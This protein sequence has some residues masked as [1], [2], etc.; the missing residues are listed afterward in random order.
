MQKKKII[1]DL[2]KCSVTVTHTGV[3]PLKAEHHSILAQSYQKLPYVSQLFTGPQLGLWA[4]VNPVNPDVCDNINMIYHYPEDK[5]NVTHRFVKLLNRRNVF[6]KPKF[7]NISQFPLCNSWFVLV[8]QNKTELPKTRLVSLYPAAPLI[9][10]RK[11]D[12]IFVEKLNAKQFRRSQKEEHYSLIQEPGSTY[13]GHVSTSSSSS[14][15]I[16]QSIISR[17]S[18]LSMLLEKLEKNG[19]IHRLENHV[20][21]PL[22]WSICLL[23]FN[24][25]PF[26]HIFQ[27]I[28]GKTAGPTTFS[29]SIGQQLTN[30]EKLPVVDYEPIDCSVPDIDRNL[31][32]KDQQYLLDI[33]NAIT[34]GHCPEDLA[35]RDPGPL[36]HSRWLTAAN[37]VLRLYISSSY[38][39][40][41][42]K[43]IVGFNLKLYVPVWF[44]IKKNKYFTDGPKHVFQAIQTSR[45][46][47]DELLQVVDPVI[48]RNAFFG[49]PE[50]V[51]IAMLDKR[52]HI[53]KLGYRR[54]LKARQTVTKKKTVRNFVLPKINF[55][56]SDYIEIINWNSCVIYPPPLLR[57][58]S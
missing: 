43:E 25:L 10:G 29:G 32:S 22:Q 52:E 35:N 45:Y 51:L 53:R 50:N 34:L 17:L 5:P 2:Q 40:E 36:S 11:D 31:L 7:A 16:T 20:G 57:D 47:S 38:P 41:N 28:D 42:L 19:V 12:T 8:E 33:S 3:K 27:Y 18:E 56:A 4:L 46:F 44:A 23:H 39:S 21:R 13:I 48:Q 14:N 26:R 9:D 55:Q 37:R 6:K 24:E 30:C 49:H 58:L 15:N 54:I 1:N